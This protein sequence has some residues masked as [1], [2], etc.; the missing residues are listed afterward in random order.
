M[1]KDKEW[2]K[3]KLNTEKYHRGTNELKTKTTY[4]ELY[5]RGV[6]DGINVALEFI[7]QLDELEVK[8]LDKKIKELDSYNDEL[9][10][11]NNQLRN[12]LDNQEV[13]SQEWI[14][15]HKYN[16]YIGKPFVYVDDL[17]SLIVPKQEKPIIPQ[18]VADYIE[19]WKHEGLSLS[20]WLAFDHDN[21][22]ENKTEKWLYHNDDE[23]KRHREFT[24]IDAIRYG[25]EVEKEPVYYAKIKGHEFI[26]RIPT[27]DEDT[28]ENTSD[29]YRSI[30]FVL[31]SD[32]DLIIDMKDS[33][34]SGAK[35]VMTMSQWNNLGIN[36]SNADFEEVE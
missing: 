25:Y 34:L 2:L 22:D 11:D 35:H 18:F 15:E 19:K 13:L 29:Y 9:I 23:T 27:F 17:Q 10:R 16:H 5:D 31:Q 3:Q 6:S 20:E 24:F 26:Q 30:Y 32:G 21:N 1:K 14:D 8:Q 7:E 4:G 28:G 33:G 36:D 12:T